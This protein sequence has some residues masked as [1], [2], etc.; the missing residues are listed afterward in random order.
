MAHHDRTPFIGKY[1]SASSLFQTPGVNLCLAIAATR[2]TNVRVFFDPASDTLSPHRGYTGKNT[3]VV[4]P[5]SGEN[6]AKGEK[7]R[8]ESL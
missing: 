6:S 5:R 4:E 8:K 3:V 1:V 2:G 7:G